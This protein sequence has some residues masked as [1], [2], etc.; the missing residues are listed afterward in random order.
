MSSAP[1]VACP[2][3]AALRFALHVLQ[4]VDDR[5][6]VV[7]LSDVLRSEPYSIHP[8]RARTLIGLALSPSDATGGTTR[9]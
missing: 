5:H 9:V 4:H 1:T 2:S 6:P 7:T 3:V 8:M